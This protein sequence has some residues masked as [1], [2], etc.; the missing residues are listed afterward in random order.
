MKRCSSGNG[1]SNGGSNGDS[2]SCNSH[3]RSCD[4]NC[5][6]RGRDRD[7]GVV[8]SPSS[9]NCVG[10]AVVDECSGRRASC[11]VADRAVRDVSRGSGGAGLAS[12]RGLDAVFRKIRIGSLSADSGF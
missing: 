1:G 7:R 5:L 12:R 2:G 9:E 6:S 4:R 3:S 10:N 11:N 8:K